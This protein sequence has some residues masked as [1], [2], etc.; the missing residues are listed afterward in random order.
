VEVRKGPLPSALPFLS[1]AR[2]NSL[3]TT[4]IRPE[5]LPLGFLNGVKPQ[6]GDPGRPQNH[7]GAGHLGHGVTPC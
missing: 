6:A 7:S 3:S 4:S 2:A 1:L 5:G